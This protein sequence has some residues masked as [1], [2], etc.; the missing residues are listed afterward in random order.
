MEKSEKSLKTLLNEYQ[1]NF[2]IQGQ[3]TEGSSSNYTPQLRGEEE[4]ETEDP[5][6]EEPEEVLISLG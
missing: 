5:P 3:K 4:V 6:L 2:I 1:H